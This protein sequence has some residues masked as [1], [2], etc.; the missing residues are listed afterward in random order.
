MLKRLKTVRRKKDKST[1]S[2]DGGGEK[3]V[4]HSKSSSSDLIAEATY[5]EPRGRCHKRTRSSDQSSQTDFHLHDD[6]EDVDDVDG[7]VDAKKEIRINEKS[8]EK[9]RTQKHTLHPVYIC[10]LL[11]LV[12][13]NFAAFSTYYANST[14]ALYRMAL[15]LISGILVALFLRKF[16]GLNLFKTQDKVSER[17]V[18][19]IVT[20]IR[21][22][23]KFIMADYDEDMDEFIWSFFLF[24]LSIWILFLDQVTSN[25]F[26]SA[27]N[28]L[29]VK[30]VLTLPKLY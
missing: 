13:F 9:T 10:V 17:A 11:I 26:A 19:T 4:K 1:K 18:L 7:L 8:E 12:G 29:R 3:G 20:Q 16:I 28:K 21:L 15:S 24:N 23:Y 14:I 27:F 2:E 6:D 30:P 5:V 25:P 22:V